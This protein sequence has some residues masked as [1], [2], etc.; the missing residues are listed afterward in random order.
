MNL[1]PLGD[2]VLIKPLAQPTE[3]ES[4]ILLAEQKQPEEIG[5]V[6]AVGLARHQRKEEA[7]SLADTLIAIVGSEYG[8]D[9]HGDHLTMINSAELL[10]DLVRPEPCAKVGDTVLF[11]WASGQE[12]TVNDER[13]LLMREAD[14][15]AVY[16]E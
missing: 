14:L 1:R 6:V 2:R 15:M 7:D 16:E 3:T 5:T 11:S 8:V 13:F 9:P 4:G 12:L 10:R